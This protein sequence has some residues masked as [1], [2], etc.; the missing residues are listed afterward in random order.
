MKV[1]ALNPPSKVTKNVIRDVLYGCWC[2][3]KRIG[4]ATI[5]PYS[6]LLVATVLKANGHSVSL[7]DALAEKKTLGD[8]LDIISDYE[9]LILSTS[10]M[11]INE[12]A[13]TLFQLKEK[14]PSLKTI[15]FGSHPTY[16]PRYTLGKKGIDII[17]RREPEYIIRDLLNALEKN[18]DSWKKIKGIGCREGGEY[19]LNEPYPFIQN[20]D[21]LSFP[22]RDM[23]P[24]D[25]D[26]FNPIIR[27]WP[28]TTAVTSRGCPGRCTFCTAPSFYGTKLR[29]RSGESVLKELR[30]IR[31]KGYREIYFRDETFTFFKERNKEICQ[32]MIK[33][34]IDLAWICNARVGTIDKTMMELMKRAGC[35]LIKFGVESGVQ[36]ILDRVKKGIKIEETREAFVWA[37]EV[38]IDTHAHVML[39]L[40]G[41]TRETIDRT[42]KFVKEIRPTTASFGICTPYPG[43]PLFEEVTKENPQ[44]RDGSTADLSS[45]HTK[46]FFNEIFVDLG[47]GELEKS[48][49]RAYRN[50]YLRPSYLL[51]RLKEIKS[52]ND[53]KRNVIAGLKIFDFTLRGD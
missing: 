1:L 22:D 7:L 37:N 9:V 28:Y 10:T 42:I 13:Q 26:Y 21:E 6:L 18:D 5:P 45:L 16:M 32:G 48:V 35:H 2:K 15:V 3:G 52:R 17:V 30:I 53:V 31:E 50:F 4:G 39:G 49:R 38:G 8:I 24:K 34:K 20:L 44:I 36:E 19:R 12:D 14:N 43:T 27:R 25:F 29:Y 40:P 11:T 51:S 47:K 23:L 33:D 41:E 46:G